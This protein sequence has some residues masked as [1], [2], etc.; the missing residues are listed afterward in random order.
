MGAHHR[1]VDVI[2]DVLEEARAVAVLQTFEE[3]RT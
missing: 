1:T 2:D 3:V